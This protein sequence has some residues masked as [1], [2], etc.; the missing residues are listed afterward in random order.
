[1][2][3]ILVNHPGA[4]AGTPHAQKLALRNASPPLQVL[5]STVQPHGTRATPLSSLS[6]KTGFCPALAPLK[7]SSNPLEMKLAT[8]I[9]FPALLKLR[10]V[11]VPIY[12]RSTVTFE[13][14]LRVT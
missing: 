12:R 3:F 7:A 11:R 1:M 6:S 5:P 13:F 9:S 8:L 10:R 4:K 2:E 14:T